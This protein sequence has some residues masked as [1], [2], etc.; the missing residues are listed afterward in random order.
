MHL[1]YIA[2]QQLPSNFFKE[3]SGTCA[4]FWQED[5]F[6]LATLIKGSAFY[7]RGAH[8]DYVSDYV[9]PTPL[10]FRQIYEPN[11]YY[12]FAIL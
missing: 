2:C 7:R 5:V 3:K 1:K 9:P 4:Q 12:H 6:D 11:R 10:E 8:Q